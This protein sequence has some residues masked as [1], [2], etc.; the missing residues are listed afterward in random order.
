M[1]QLFV[2]GH[3][4]FVSFGSVSNVVHV[5]QSSWDEEINLINVTNS[6]TNQTFGSN[7]GNIGIAAKLANVLDGR[8]TVQMFLDLLAPPYGA[9]LNLIP[10]ASGAWYFFVDG[11][12][13]LYFSIPIIVRRIHYESQVMGGVQ[14]STDVELNALA[15]Q[16]GVAGAGTTTMEYDRPG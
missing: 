9:S 7:P 15:A 1:A 6:A 2:S 5:T 11:S 12:N 3:K 13:N 4:N 14:W 16:T 10:G 8:G